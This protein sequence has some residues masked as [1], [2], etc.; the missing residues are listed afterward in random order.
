M[1]HGENQMYPEQGTE[2]KLN[3]TVTDAPTRIVTDEITYTH[4]ITMKIA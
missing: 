1:G 4:N 2:T 3:L